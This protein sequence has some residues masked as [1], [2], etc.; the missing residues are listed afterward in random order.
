MIIYNWN[1]IKALYETPNEFALGTG[2]SVGSFDG[3]HQGHR[4]IMKKLVQYSEENNLVPGV[5]TFTR[6][7][8]FYKHSSN[9]PGDIST[10]EQRLKLFEQA[11]I[12]FVILVDFTEDFAKLSG[13]EFLDLVKNI[14]NL[15]F[16]CEGVDFRCGYKGAT[17]IQ[18]ISY[19]AE[20]NCVATTFVESVIYNPGTDEEERISSSYI[21]QMIVKGFFSTVQELLTRPYA[22]DLRNTSFKINNKTLSV[23]TKNL[24]QIIPP[25]GIY[26]LKLEYKASTSDC[27]TE[28]L[29]NEINVSLDSTDIK[30]DDLMSLIF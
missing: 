24:V 23:S 19:W 27:R 14:F 16:I 26:H 21:R 10:L 30:E 11:G 13:V 12:K 3:L 18:S 4:T 20:K 28:I 22:L 2:I 17:D 15:K 29:D 1:D 6:P 5:I 7:L 25:K 8:P 9:Y